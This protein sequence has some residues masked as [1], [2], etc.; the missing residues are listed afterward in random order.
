MVS[1]ALAAKG[2]S[3]SQAPN[4]IQAMSLPYLLGANVR[5][6]PLRVESAPN[7]ADDPTRDGPLRRPVR[8]RPS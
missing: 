3:S 4:R 5:L 8:A 2:R 7:P 1:S 6:A